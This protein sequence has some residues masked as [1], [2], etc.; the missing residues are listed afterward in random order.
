[1]TSPQAKIL[2]VIACV[3][4]VYAFVCQIRISRKAG[5]LSEWLRKECPDLWSEVP[6]LARSWN[7]GQPGLKILY[8]KNVVGHPKFDQEYEELASME[9]KQLWGVGIGAMCIGLVI[10]GSI[11][12]GWQL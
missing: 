2:I 9:R 11:Y 7:G 1:M 12:W 6:L 5:K 10:M 4:I 8:R 3:S